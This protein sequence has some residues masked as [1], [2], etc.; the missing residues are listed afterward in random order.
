VIYLG[1]G[2]QTS[3]AHAFRTGEFYPHFGLDRISEFHEAQD[4]RYAEAAREAS[5]RHAKPVLA[6]TD[7]VHTDRSYGNAGLLAVRQGGRVCYASAR[8]AVSTLRALV[9]YAEFRRSL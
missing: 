5:Q 4:R 8:R 1:L 7:L 2:I 6:A 9:D 3:Q